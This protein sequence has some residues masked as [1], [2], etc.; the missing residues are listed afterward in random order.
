MKVLI[1]EDNAESSRLFSI[2]M[3]SMG[4]EVNEAFDGKAALEKLRNECYDI[5]I[6]D[7]HLPGIDGF[8]IMKE[9]K[10]YPKPAPFTIAVSALA[11]AGD[12]ERILSSGCNRYISK[13]ISLQQFRKEIEDVLSLLSRGHKELI[14]G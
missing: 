2:I 1:V 14:D 4:Q 13:P 12:K 6:L 3:K 8:T 5:V 9:M 10:D 11:M 7:M